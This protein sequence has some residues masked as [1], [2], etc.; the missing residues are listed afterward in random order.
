MATDEELKKAAIKKPSAQGAY[1]SLAGISQGTKE[2]LNYYGQGYQQS[3]AVTDAKN[4]LQSIVDKRPGEFTSDYDPQ[5]K[6]LY[7]QIMNRPGFTYDVSKDALYKQYKNQYATMG[8]QAMQDTVGN[9]AA[10]TGGYGNSWATTAGSQAYQAYLQQLNNV[11]PELYQ[12]AYARYAQEGQDMK[13]RLSLTQGLRDTEYGQYRDTVSD[14]QADR[15]Y[16]QSAYDS[17]YNRDYSAWMD[18]LSYWQALAGQENQNYWNQ[19]NYDFEMQK[20]LDAMSKSGGGSGGSGG[21][22]KSGSSYTGNKATGSPPYNKNLLEVIAT[23]QEGGTPTNQQLEKAGL[24]RGDWNDFVS[25][26]NEPASTR[27]KQN[28]QENELSKAL[29]IRQGMLLEKNKSKTGYYSGSKT[30]QKELDELLGGK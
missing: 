5:I 11:I 3:Q 9:A 22:G 6:T 29:A 30:K 26:R 16:A 21:G 28:T 2:N 27:I 1:S 15:G 23:Q 10:L 18:M 8:Q 25:G 17:E 4:Y 24:S 19:M 14:W 20:Y 13:D 7:E 12:N